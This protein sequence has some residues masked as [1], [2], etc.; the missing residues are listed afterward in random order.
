MQVSVE[1]ANIIIIHV[2]TPAID[3]TLL[4]SH[5]RTYKNVFTRIPK[6]KESKPTWYLYNFLILLLLHIN[7]LN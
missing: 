5:Y 3:S 4:R 1:W 2:T 7:S 6:I